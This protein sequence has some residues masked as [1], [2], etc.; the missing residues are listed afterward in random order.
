MDTPPASRAS[1]R[2][3]SARLLFELLSWQPIA[4][5]VHRFV[6]HFALVLVNFLHRRRKARIVLAEAETLEDGEEAADRRLIFLR[7][8]EEL[9]D[10]VL[11]R[12][13][14]RIVGVEAFGRLA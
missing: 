6:V 2:L 14:C 3:G 13:F 8:L 10:H 12:I 7:N 5:H 11:R 1:K 4:L 9:V